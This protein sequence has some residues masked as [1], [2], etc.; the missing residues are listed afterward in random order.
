MKKM[1]DKS[2]ETG[3]ISTMLFVHKV[4]KFILIT[5]SIFCIIF[6]YNIISYP[7]LTVLVSILLTIKCFLTFNLQ[8]KKSSYIK[9]FNEH[10]NEQ[11]S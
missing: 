5:L 6:S 9:S 8:A 10:Y 1:Y 4:D 7:T 2:K 11:S 3:F